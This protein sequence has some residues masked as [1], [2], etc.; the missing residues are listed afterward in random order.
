M[1]ITRTASIENESAF[2]VGMEVFGV[3][4]G[5]LGFVVV[6]LAGGDGDGVLYIVEEGWQNRAG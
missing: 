2:V 1:R 5:E 6:Q 3:E 4:A